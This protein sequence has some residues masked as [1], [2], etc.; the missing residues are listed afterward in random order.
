MRDEGTHSKKAPRTV[1]GE[2]THS[3]K[4]P[5]NM[6]GEGAH[7]KKAPRIV[8]CE[9]THSKKSS[10]NVRGEGTHINKVPRFRQDRKLHYVLYVV[11]PG[12]YNYC[13]LIKNVLID[14]R[15]LLFVK[16]NFR[17]FQF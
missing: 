13:R 11:V 3:K 7:S 2:G 14:E 1:R 4:S 5:R 15:I 10:R 12:N 8:R 6:R 16:Y 17:R 9:G